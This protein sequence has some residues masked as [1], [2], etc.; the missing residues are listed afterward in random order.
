MALNK[1]GHIYLNKVKVN[2]T[3]LKQQLGAMTEEEKKRPIYLK[4]DKNVAYGMVVTI[5]GDIKESGFEKLGM[6][7]QPSAEK[8]KR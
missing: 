2:S 4:A 7:T 3:L 5:M 8:E 1:E 6:I